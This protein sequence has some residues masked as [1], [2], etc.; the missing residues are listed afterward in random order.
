MNEIK[1]SSQIADQ[2]TVVS[3]EPEKCKNCDNYRSSKGKDIPACLEGLDPKTCGER[4]FPLDE[5]K[6]S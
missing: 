1:K 3:A 6:A 2:E 4:Y 5:K